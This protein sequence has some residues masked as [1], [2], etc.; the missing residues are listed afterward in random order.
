V[1]VA[2]QWHTLVLEIIWQRTHSVGSN[3]IGE[4]AEMSEREV[5]KGVNRNVLEKIE[6]KFRKSSELSTEQLTDPDYRLR[7]LEKLNDNKLP[8]TCSKCH[9]CRR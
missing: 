3:K 7:Q 6:P 9:H 4:E 5:V 2:G 8:I 1:A